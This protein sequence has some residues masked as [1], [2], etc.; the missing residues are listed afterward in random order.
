[1]GNRPDSVN[2]DVIT[3]NLC[4]P[5]KFSIRA[6]LVL[7]VLAAILTSIYV[8]LNPPNPEVAVAKLRAR[9][10]GVSF[11]GEIQIPPNCRRLQSSYPYEVGEALPE[12]IARDF[13]AFAVLKRDGWH[14][15]HT[16]ANPD[17]LGYIEF[18]F[19][20]EIGL[21]EIATPREVLAAIDVYDVEEGI[22]YSGLL[23][24]FV[25]TATDARAP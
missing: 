12:H 11:V 23:D 19:K 5:M 15:I 2:P 21:V 4:S 7:T 18:L 3:L 10:Q 20:R 1:M 8:A 6:L 13:M 14:V 16:G 24:Y 25:D 22:S 9:K 17:I